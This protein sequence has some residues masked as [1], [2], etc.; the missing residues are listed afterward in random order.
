MPR[1]L[2]FYLFKRIGLGVLVIQLAMCVPVVL[3]Y[4]LS[5]LPPAAVR[6]GLVWPAVQG[7][8]PTVAYVA[9]PMAAGVATALEFSRMA[10]EGMIAVLYALRLSAWAI[11]RPAIALASLCLV[12]GLFLSNFIA[13]Y[14]VGTMQDV[15]NVVRN[16]LNHRMLEPAHFYTF[17]AG[18]KT[19]YLE[20]WETPD[21][22]ANLF[23]RQ[24]SVEKMEE[25]V[26]TAAHAEFRRNE[27][28]VVVALTKGSIQTRS[29]MGG[30]VRISNF[31]E[32]ALLL[33]MQGSGSLPPRAW[34]GVYELGAFD[35][36]AQLAAARGDP[37]LLAEWTTEAAM[38]IVVPILAFGHT[39][40]AVALILAFGN[41]TGRRGASGQLFVIA[42][43]AVHIVFLV[44]LQTLIRANAWL[45]V[46]VL[47][48][49]ILEIGV[50]FY[51][52]AKVNFGPKRAKRSPPGMGP[53][54]V[55]SP[56]V[57]ASAS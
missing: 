24:L 16:S 36:S 42:V 29:L 52:I 6:G 45:A 41:V 18:A 10:S 26:I 49:V 2:F 11:I 39:V 37:R 54:S 14:Y 8:A 55:S 19:L 53:A 4:L 23:V 3:A 57:A 21:I 44:T 51:L 33:P 20:R 50:S 15:L 7:V 27:R 5:S 32:Y 22:A 43:P 46:V 9:L 28:G 1:L 35:F 40:M 25:Q 34:R 30:E 47:A 38:R 13:P 31:D 56:T 48:M 12:L 17:D